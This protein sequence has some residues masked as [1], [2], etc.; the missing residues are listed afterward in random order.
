ISYSGWNATT[1]QP[2]G[3][4]TATIDDPATGTKDVVTYTYA[5]SGG[6][7]VQ[8]PGDPLPGT[9]TGGEWESAHIANITIQ[10]L[11]RQKRNVSDQVVEM[12]QYTDFTSLSYDPSDS[13]WSTL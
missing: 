8:G 9:P 4:V 2:T 3:P 12:D 5:G 11:V 13:G 1:N 6:L 7:P 10:S